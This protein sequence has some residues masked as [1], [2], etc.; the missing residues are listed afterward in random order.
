MDQLNL[1]VEDGKDTLTVFDGLYTDSAEIAEL[2]V[3]EG[4]VEICENAFRGFTHL[5]SVTLPRTL[6]RIGACAFS[7]CAN[8]RR[9]DMQ[10]GITE[11]CEHRSAHSLRIHCEKLLYS[12]PK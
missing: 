9:V 2:T 12:F 5:R 1:H 8:L 7:G 11:I 10:H 3:P 4:V 6:L